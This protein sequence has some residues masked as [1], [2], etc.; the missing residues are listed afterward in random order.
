MM[1]M[2]GEDGEVMGFVKV[3]CDE[4]E[5]RVAREALERSRAELAEAVE[6]K[7]EARAAAEAATK[8]KDQFMAIL[9]HELRT[10]LTPVMLGLHTL[11]RRKD[12]P[13]AAQEILG[14]I[15]RCVQ[16]EM[17]LISDLL[18][19]SRI[20]HGKLDL[21][22]KPV[23]LHQIIEHAIAVVQADFESKKQ[24]FEVRLEA[25]DTALTGDPD[26]LEQVFWNLLKNAS[27]F[28][29]EEGHVSVV[30]KNENSR[31]VIEISDTG[32][33]FSPQLTEEIFDAFSQAGHKGLKGAGGLGLGLAIAKAAV[34]A[35]SGE[36]SAVSDGDGKGARFTVRLPLPQTAP[37]NS[38]R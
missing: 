21:Q 37:D 2:R 27:K 17:R 4:T 35:H 30:S 26:R 22:L 7:E 15:K 28:T 19:I 31:A 10:P 33:G 5:K 24:V 20:T 16:S 11:E 8:A 36:I 32:I 18:D 34:L 13:A 6:A 1:S 12:V 38:L 29:P 14:T 25:T 3:F 9:S 23:D